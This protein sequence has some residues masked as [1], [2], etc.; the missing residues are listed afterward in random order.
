MKLIPLT[1][2]MHALVDDVDYDYL[3]QWKWTYLSTGYAYRQYTVGKKSNG[4]QQLKTILMHRL[5]TGTPKGIDTDHINGNRLDN[6]RHNLR[7]CTRSQNNAN[8]LVVRGTTSK[9]KGVY[10]E[11]R[12]GR[13]TS[14]IS[15]GGRKISL[16]A[17]AT[18]EAAHE[19]YKAA[20]VVYFGAFA[21]HNRQMPLVMGDRLD[22]WAPN[23]FRVSDIQQM[24]A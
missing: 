7:T 20:S 1:R 5:L 12:T 8:S 10:L 9:L 14:Q 13:W 16:G 19:A 23:W 18:E 2:G 15:V 21:G 3:M 11:K 17:Y 24:A 6:R 4:K 22:S